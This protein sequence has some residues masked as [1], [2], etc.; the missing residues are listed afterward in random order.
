M[1]TTAK[2]DYSEIVSKVVCPE[3]RG[4]CC[5]H[6]P[7]VIAGE[8]AC[9]TKCPETLVKSEDCHFVLTMGNGVGLFLFLEVGEYGID[10][11]RTTFCKRLSFHFYVSDK[12][13]VE[14]NMSRRGV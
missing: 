10:R 1:F 7:E 3:T 6:C 8:I 4:T 2:V 11:N 12:V 14:L 13:K 5:L 9:F